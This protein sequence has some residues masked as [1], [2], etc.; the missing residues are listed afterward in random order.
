MCQSAAHSHGGLLAC[1]FLLGL[2]EAGLWPAI[3]FHI[4]F[5]YPADRLPLRIALLSACGQCS[6]TFSGLLAFAIAYLNGAAGLS[7]WRWVFILEGIPALILGI[8]CL[9]CLPNYPEPAFFLSAQERQAVLDAMPKNQPTAGSKTWDSEQVKA[10]LKDPVFYTF[11]LIWTCLAI[12]GWGVTVAFP[13]VIYALRLQ[14]TSISQLMTMPPYAIGSVVLLLVAHLIR[15]K[16]VKAF[17]CAI[18]LEIG[19]CACYVL[20]VVVRHAIVKYVFVCLTL[21]C[22]T[23][24][25]PILWPERIRAAQGTTSTGLAIGVTSSLA[26]LAGIVGPQL[27]QSRFGP[28][29]Q[30]SFVTSIGLLA[31]CILATVASWAMLKRREVVHARRQSEESIQ[32]R[33]ASIAMCAEA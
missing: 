28:T 12:G 29:Y 6:G 19:C 17:P 27:Y 10:T 7:G 14:G 33:G 5:W 13:S 30:V 1:R 15:K 18:A 31:V 8:A 3:M 9:F 32:G 22:C 23:A 26:H 21:V 2:A 4:S 11:L 24:I 20:L 25:L 16:K